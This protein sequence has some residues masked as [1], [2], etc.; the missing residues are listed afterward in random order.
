[1]NRRIITSLLDTDLYKCNMQRVFINHFADTVATYE[2]KCRSDIKFTEKMFEDIMWQIDELCKLRFTPDEIDYVANIYYHKN[3]KFFYEF[4]RLFQLRREYI[5]VQFING[6]LIIKASGPIWSV[7]MFEIYV[8]AIVNEVYFAHKQDEL[9]Q[10]RRMQATTEARILLNEKINKLANAPI[11]IN[12]SDFGTRRRFSKEWQKE[13]VRACNH[14]YKCPQDND[15]LSLI[16]SG[17]SN[18]ALAKELNITPIGTMAHEYLQLG[19]ALDCVTV[20]NSQ[21]YMLQKWADEYRGD[22]GIALS[23]TLGVDYFLRHDFDKYFGKLFDGVRHDSGDPIAFGEKMIQHY[24]CKL[25]IDP[26]TKT[27]VFSDGLNVD[28]MI[29]LANHFDGR[30]KVA[31]GIGTNLTNDFGQWYTPINIVMKMTEAN[32]KPVAKISDTLGKTMCKDDN[33]LAYLRSVIA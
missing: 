7:S 32:G 28:T 21:K 11:K 13:V 3:A 27:I 2:F 18:V 17:T 14:R 10:M 26:M 23:D 1:M 29:T 33:Y 31:F 25:G 5:T 4:L 16:F 19:Q 30:I 22:L 24:V 8:L 15:N 12:F 9:G 20:A 6:E